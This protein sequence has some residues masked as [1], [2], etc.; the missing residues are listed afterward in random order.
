MPSAR[1]EPPRRTAWLSQGLESLPDALRGKEEAEVH[2][3][4]VVVGSGYGGAVAAAELA[5]CRDAAS[6][7][8]VA[9]CVGAAASAP[10]RGVA[11]LR[12]EGVEGVDV[13]MRAP[14]EDGRGIL[15][16]PG[17]GSRPCG[18][19]ASPDIL[20][21]EDR[22][23]VSHAARRSVADAGRPARRQPGPRRGRGLSASP[24]DRHQSRSARSVASAS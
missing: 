12:A 23:P 4:I 13:D 8:P 7:R 16:G 19:V 21:A 14:A 22:P 24:T 15:F 5:G 3:D 17:H 6:G 11:A 2:F 1:D 18:A 20:C 9:L 10:R